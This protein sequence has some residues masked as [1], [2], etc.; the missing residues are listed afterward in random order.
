M[1][2]R[3]LV[4]GLCVL[5]SARQPGSDG[6]IAITEDPLGGGRIQPFGERRQHNCDLLG[7]G[8]QTIQSGVAPSTEGGVTGLAAECLDLF[9]ATML[10]IPD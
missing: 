10:A 2:E 8:F 1:A 4:Q 9:S 7:G 3:A 5:A 6:G